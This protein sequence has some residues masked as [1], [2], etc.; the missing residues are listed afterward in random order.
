MGME[1]KR[2]IAWT[3]SSGLIEDE[4]HCISGVRHCGILGVKKPFGDD[5]ENVGED[6]LRDTTTIRECGRCTYCTDSKR[7][8]SKKGLIINQSALL[9]FL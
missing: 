5:H 8:T 9:W 3:L 6:T 2:M 7:A 4:T 1:V